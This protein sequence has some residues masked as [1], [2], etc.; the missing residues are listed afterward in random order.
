MET[1][2]PLATWLPA[3]IYRLAL[4]FC[5]V[6]AAFMLLPGL[7]EHAVPVRVRLLAGLAAALCI[8]PLAGPAVPVPGVW[9]ILAAMALEVTTGTLLGT[10]AR[11]LLSAVQTAGQIIGQNIGLSNAFVFGVGSDNAAVVG[12][13]L[14]VGGLAALFTLEGHHSGLRALADSYAM[15]P[16]GAAPPLAASAEVV[17]EMAARAFRLAMQFAMPFL[18]L[19]M[20]FNLAMAGINRAMPAMPVF[21]IGAPALLMAGLQLL[22]LVSPGI[23]HELLGAYAEVF[24]LPR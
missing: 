13:A 6:S 10:L 23:L 16:L 5:R 9:S 20:L 15:V 18:A 1:A 14:Y 2:L 7:S 22:A 11:L 4:V 24:V 12:A 17:T 19:A 21:M 8:A 3:E